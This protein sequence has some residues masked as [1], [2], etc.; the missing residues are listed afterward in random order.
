MRTAKTDRV[1][2]RGQEGLLGLSF[3]ESFFLGFENEELF[4]KL[5]NFSKGCA[6]ECC[7]EGR[8]GW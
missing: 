3:E 7:L 6:Q 1:L 8:E 4:W 2:G 5:S